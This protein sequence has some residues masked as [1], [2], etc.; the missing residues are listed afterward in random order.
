MNNI[1]L[2][3]ENKLKKEA[4]VSEPFRFQASKRE[5]ERVISALIEYAMI[6]VIARITKFVGDKYFEHARGI[7][8]LKSKKLLDEYKNYLDFF[9]IKSNMEMTRYFWYAKK[10]G[11][12]HQPERVLEIGSGAGSY[13]LFLTKMYPSIKKYWMIDFPEMLSATREQLK[14][15]PSSHVSYRLL[16]YTSLDEVPKNYFDVICN[17]TSFS[18]MEERTIR[19]YFDL[20]YSSA[21]NNALWYHVNRHKKLVNHDGSKSDNNPLLFPYHASDNVLFFEPDEFHHVTRSRIG[22]VPTATYMR[23]ARIQKTNPHSP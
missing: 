10:L 2:F 8:F 11:K 12:Y 5:R 6:C 15:Y 1:S 16:S 13:A 20:V 14:K 7:G 3:W 17:F 23:I 18:E 21:Q 22:L 19:V 4:D 9:G